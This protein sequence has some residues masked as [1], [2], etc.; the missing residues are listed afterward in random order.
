MCVC[1]AEDQIT[2]EV[3]LEDAHD[4]QTGL[5]VFKVGVQGGRGI[6]GLWPRVWMWIVVVIINYGLWPRVSWVGCMMRA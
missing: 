5:D 6:M 3:G 2:H 1:V 4:P